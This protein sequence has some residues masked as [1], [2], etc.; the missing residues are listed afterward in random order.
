MHRRMAATLSAA[1]VS[2]SL[3]FLNP[4]PAWS[5]VPTLE[6][7]LTFAELA[8]FLY[9]Q[10]RWIKQQA[11]GCSSQPPQ[12]HQENIVLPQWELS[13]E[14]AAWMFHYT[15]L[16]RRSTGAFAKRHH[17]RPRE[18]A[19]RSHIQIHSVGVVCPI[20]CLVN[21]EVIS[22]LRQMFDPQS[23]SSRR[24]R[25]L[26]FLVENLVVFPNRRNHRREVP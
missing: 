25:R 8:I 19:R 4:S 12:H 1:R 22:P 6:D 20:A 3:R 24:L 13:D 17:L 2:R 23:G 16:Q 5:F 9:W 18:L 15:L 21:R 14:Q 10:Y 7:N 11:S 26:F